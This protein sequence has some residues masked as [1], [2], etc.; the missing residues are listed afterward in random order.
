MVFFCISKMSY[1]F[2]TNLK[3]L[4]HSQIDYI[5]EWYQEEVIINDTSSSEHRC[6]CNRCIKIAHICRNEV[7]GNVVKMGTACVKKIGLEHNTSRAREVARDNIIRLFGNGVYEDITDMSQYVFDVLRDYMLCK[8][9]EDIIRWMDMYKTNPVMLAVI[10][11]VY[12]QKQQ[13]NQQELST[14]EA[15]RQKEIVEK[16]AQ[17]QKEIAQQKEKEVR[18]AQIQ[19]EVEEERERQLEKELWIQS[20]ETNRKRMDNPDIDKIRLY[21]Q[22]NRKKNDKKNTCH[23]L[24]KNNEICRCSKPRFKLSHILPYEDCSSCYKWKCRC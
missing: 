16:E 14:K 5:K 17:R 12:N 8:P 23:C 21:D 15:Q 24:L 20:I 13:Q 19:R 7:N 9:I 2:E 6:I 11:K 1:S 3:K 22:D 18:E 4:S 10:Q